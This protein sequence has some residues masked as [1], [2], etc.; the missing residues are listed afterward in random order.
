[1]F[2]IEIDDHIQTIRALKNIEQ[3]IKQTADILTTSIRKGGKILICGN[4]G[5]ATDAQHF[6]GEIVGRFLMER[7]GWPVIALGAD[8]AS[9]TSI[10]ND[11]GFSDVF[12]RQVEAFGRSGD[13][14]IGI[15]TSGNSENIIK[16]ATT[17]KTR[18]IR[19]IGLLGGNGG[20]LRDHVDPAL[21]VASTHT[22]RIQ[23]AHIFI[24]HYLAGCIEKTLMRQES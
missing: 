15:S 10:A 16:A 3:E 21:I 23:E 12:S 20:K 4:G 22:P 2:Q 13:V 14:L 11:Y 17:A 9:L 1:M 5:S 8:I 18:Q 19:T 6:S 7:P 24:L